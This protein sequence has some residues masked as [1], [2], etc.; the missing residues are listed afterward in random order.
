MLQVR[1]SIALLLPVLWLVTAMPCPCEALEAVDA[2]MVSS[3][4]TTQQTSSDGGQEGCWQIDSARC[5][6][7]R[8]VS[9]ELRAGAQVVRIVPAPV[10]APAPKIFPEGLATGDVF[11]LPQSWQF[12]WRTAPPP[13]T[14]SLLS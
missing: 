10:T 3:S 6:W 8:S 5:P 11:F 12:L 9:E 7:R 2:A 14:P 13:R 4:G 1:A